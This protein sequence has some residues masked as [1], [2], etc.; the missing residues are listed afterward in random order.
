MVFI[1][2]LNSHSLYSWHNALKVS[3]GDEGILDKTPFIIRYEEL[4][5][6]MEPTSSSESVGLGAFAFFFDGEDGA[7]SVMLSWRFI[8]DAD[9]GD[10]VAQLE[11][12]TEPPEQ[13][14]GVT[15]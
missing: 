12:V 1:R 4:I 13:E 2:N 11:D 3:T 7:T 6:K 5:A 9:I 14:L 8:T 10:E 15:T